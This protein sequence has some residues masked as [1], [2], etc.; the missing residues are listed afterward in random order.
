MRIRIPDDELLRKT[1]ELVEEER[2]IGVE[3]L[4]HL[5]EIELRK[6]YLERGYPSGAAQRRIDA[7][8]LLKELPEIEEK[9]KTGR[10]SLCTASR[11]QSFLRRQESRAGSARTEE[12]LELR[13]ALAK[14]SNRLELVELLEG[15]ST[16][17]VER[18]LAE[19]APGI[20]TRESA[21]YESADRLKLTLS[22]SE[23]LHRDLLKL[24]SLLSHRNPTMS[25]EGLLAELAKIALDRL[26]PERK[27][28]RKSA[29]L[30]TLETAAMKHKI[31]SRFIPRAVKNAVFRRDDARCA[32]VDP[33]TGRRCDSQYQ[34]QFD[35][36][37]PY[38]R[39]GGTTMENLRLLC[40]AHN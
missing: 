18:K 24:K 38:A 29:P 22:M 11:V 1:R 6:L 4:H 7:M 12:A 16:R 17:D 23:E 39:G 10:L 25:W 34:L 36:V 28:K 20:A 9:I 19:I 8:R 21:T 2:R 40:A 30:P 13:E 5:K 14:K 32:F 15:K 26:D 3:V 27:A 33:A 37:I 31:S 35:H